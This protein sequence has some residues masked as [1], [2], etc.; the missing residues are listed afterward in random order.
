VPSF[1][2]G[3]FD[4]TQEMEKR[5]YE[6]DMWR[7]DV[8]QRGR[9]G[10][11]KWEWRPYFVVGEADATVLHRQPCLADPARKLYLARG[12]SGLQERIQILWYLPRKSGA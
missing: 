7:I 11:R 8:L 1:D 9:G 5:L 3:I 6:E 12:I 2:F 10:Y 4:W